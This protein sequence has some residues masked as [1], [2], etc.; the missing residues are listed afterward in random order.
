MIPEA[1][2]AGHAGKLRQFLTTHILP[3]RAA[4]LRVLDHGGEPVSGAEV[5]VVGLSRSRTNKKGYTRFYLPNDYFY[6]LVIRYGNHEEVLY[7]EQMSPG[8]AYVYRPDASSAFGRLLV[9][10]PE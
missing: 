2:I 4:R 5:L 10:S 1:P 9:L 6:S 3:R 7:E 8:G